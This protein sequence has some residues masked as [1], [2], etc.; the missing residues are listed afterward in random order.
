MN[1]KHYYYSTTTSNGR[2]FSFMAASE[3]ILIVQETHD[4]G[5]FT[6]K[7]IK[8][9][10]DPEYRYKIQKTQ[11]KANSGAHGLYD[12]LVSC[13]DNSFMTCYAD[14]ILIAAMDTVKEYKA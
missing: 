6:K 12:F 3:N 10:I 9:L 8:V 4:N 5:T 11:I 2:M 1:Y 14:D 13:Y 7:N